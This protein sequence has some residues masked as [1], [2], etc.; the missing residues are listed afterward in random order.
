LKS[1]LFDHPKLGT[2]PP[3]NT[4]SSNLRSFFLL[5]DELRENPEHTVNTNRIILDLS[6]E[7]SSRN[8]YIVSF[9]IQAK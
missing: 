9:T 7:L 6:A 5:P 3:K 8:H 1:K 4:R 2:E